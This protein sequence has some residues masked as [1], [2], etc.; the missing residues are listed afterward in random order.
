MIAFRAFDANHKFETIAGFDAD[1]VAI[2]VDVDS[3]HC[4]SPSMTY[5]IALDGAKIRIKGLIGR[6][7]AHGFGDTHQKHGVFRGGLRV[8]SL[9]IDKDR[10]LMALTS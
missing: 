8:E 6:S 3:W 9:V 1:L 5:P 2:A 10:S 4:H 7:V